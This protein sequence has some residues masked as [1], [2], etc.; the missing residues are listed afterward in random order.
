MHETTQQPANN[1]GSN[2]SFTWFAKGKVAGT[3]QNDVL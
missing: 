2:S 1:T 3:L